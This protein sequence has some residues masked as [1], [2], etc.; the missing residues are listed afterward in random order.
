MNK[1]ITLFLTLS[2]YVIG[3]IIPNTNIKAQV[4][5][6]TNF[7]FSLGDFTNWKGYQAKNTSSSTTIYFSN[8]ILYPNPDTCFHQ[9]LP[10]FVIN[11]DTSAYDPNIGS[12]LKV[13]YHLGYNKS[14]KIN[15]DEGGANANYLSYDKLITNDNCMVTFNFALI[16]ETPGHSGYQNPFAKIEVLEIDANKS[17]ADILHPSF[18]Y[19]V[20]GSQPPPVGWTNFT[21]A[22]AQGIWQNWRQVT[23]DLSNYIGHSIRLNILITGCS[24]TAHYA[25]GYFT[26]EVAPK[27]IE[28]NSCLD[29]LSDTLAIL[30]APAGFAKYEW[31]ENPND[32]PETQLNTIDYGNPLL[33]S[34]FNGALTPENKFEVLKSD[35]I[36]KN[37]FV[38]LTSITNTWNTP[39]ISYIKV[40]AYNSKPIA[41]FAKIRSSNYEVAFENRTEF[42]QNDT[43]AEIEYVWDFGDGSDLVIYNSKTNPVFM[44]I[45]PIHQYLDSNEYNVQLTVR[46]N[47]CESITNNII[48][49]TYTGIEEVI[50]D[51]ISLNIYPNPA[52]HFANIKAEGVNGNAKI[53]I[54]NEIGKQI[55]SIN[56]S[57]VNGV[58]EKQI[59]T[60]KYE[61]GVYLVKIISEGI[62]TSQK[63]IIQ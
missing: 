51:N 32:L 31:F 50:N 18:T 59:D 25:Y 33:V 57:S 8:W 22:G 10:C 48:I 40:N 30:K 60:K 55:Q 15:V 19:L 61:K 62:E 44:N 34:E 21:T 28:V 37:L 14:V 56:A 5:D 47:G 46:Y 23:M 53:I 6:G 2:L 13:P 41:K 26:G 29:N 20:L 38:K 36:S 12:L 42:P 7:D 27:I 52:S 9:N 63:L 17:K 43:N 54:Y 35:S 11:S 24:P 45:N 39:L 58:I 16:L 1:T 4:A 3:L 49:P